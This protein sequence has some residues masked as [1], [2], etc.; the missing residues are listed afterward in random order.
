M[1]KL[2]LLAIF[3]IAFTA[4]GQDQLEKLE[5]LRNEL[6]KAGN[7][8]VQDNNEPNQ[9]R[10]IDGI[11]VQIAAEE[12]VRSDEQVIHKIDTSR[13]LKLKQLHPPW[14]KTAL[15][16]QQSLVYPKVADR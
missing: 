9:K 14:N 8:P 3:A 12:N 5:N 4:C 11:W 2:S 13:E 6:I 10:Q 15:I 16:A 7:S 1:R